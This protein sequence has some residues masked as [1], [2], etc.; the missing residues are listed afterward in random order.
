VLQITNLAC[1]ISYPSFISLRS[2]TGLFLFFTSLFC[3]L[4]KLNLSP[5]F[6][7][8]TSTFFFC[9]LFIRSE[10]S[11]VELRVL[12]A[13]I[14]YFPQAILANKKDLKRFQKA[15]KQFLT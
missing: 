5:C 12:M 13:S 11:L 1:Q 14:T 8:Q 4:P 7:P 6:P 2:S 9:D 3:I 15:Q 10:Y